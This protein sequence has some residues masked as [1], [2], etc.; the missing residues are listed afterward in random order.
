MAV[1]EEVRIPVSGEPRGDVANNHHRQ[2]RDLP[3]PRL[4]SPPDTDA[5]RRVRWT[6]MLDVRADRGALDIAIDQLLRDRWQ[7]ITA[8]AD[9]PQRDR[10]IGVRNV[11]IV[12]LPGARQ[13]YHEV[14]QLTGVALGLRRQ[15][16]QRVV[17]VDR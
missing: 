14:D 2:D 17:A 3:G 8:A 11:P 4:G 6:R 10:E 15:R 5:R 12:E 13:P 9:P 16:R 1:V 7:W